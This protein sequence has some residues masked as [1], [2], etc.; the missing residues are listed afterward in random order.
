MLFEDFPQAH[1]FGIH[2]FFGFKKKS[3]RY[4]IRT[5]SR[6]ASVV[7]EI[8]F[9]KV[10]TAQSIEIGVIALFFSQLPVVSRG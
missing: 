2:L 10:I 6:S 4:V 8:G 3:E 9:L 7:N 5:P 1:K